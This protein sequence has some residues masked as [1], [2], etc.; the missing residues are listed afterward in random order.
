MNFNK[1][2]P[3]AVLDT[4][5]AMDFPNILNILKGC[6]IVI[7][8]TL[9]EELDKFK[10]KNKSARDFINN[11]LTISDKT[12]LS[13][14]G[15][16]L[17]NGCMLY[18][19]KDNLSHKEVSLDSVKNKEDFKFISE[20]KNLKE[21]YK[22]IE[23]VLLS[24]DKILKI[25][26]STLDIEVKNLEEFIIE[27]IENDSKTVI[28]KNLNNLK[29]TYSRDKDMHNS[30]KI[31]DIIFKVNK[32]SNILKS[33]KNINTL[34]KQ[35]EEYN[36]KA[37]YN[38]IYE[39]LVE[40][41]DIYGLYEL[42]KNHNYKPDYEKISEILTEYCNTLTDNKDINGLYELAEKYNSSKIYGRIFNI[43]AENKNI[44][45]LH[46]LIENKNIKDMNEKCLMEY[47][48]LTKIISS[49]IE[50]LENN[51]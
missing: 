39:I 11:F 25:T 42:I 31:S 36:S 21:K 30:S 48:N 24:S 27:Y 10:K 7:P 35:A 44:E 28:L 20:T 12:N 49:K 45:G 16:K 22:D 17:E 26:A 2:F 1:K 37:I 8:L 19:D 5:I 40:D 23:V 4:N 32:I 47:K 13:K 29:N 38:K 18:L 46:K 50:E 43:L 51:R 15:Y 3:I 33:E 9:I 6:N 34:Y 14:D 41:K